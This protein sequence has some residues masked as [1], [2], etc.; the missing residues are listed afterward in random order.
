[1]TTKWDKP[2]LWASSLVPSERKNKKN[3]GPR[4]EKR[5]GL[6]LSLPC[7]WIDTRVYN[8]ALSRIIVQIIITIFPLPIINAS[9]YHSS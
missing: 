1:M 6:R 9:I 2:A 8:A 7:P 5:I 4:M 3:H